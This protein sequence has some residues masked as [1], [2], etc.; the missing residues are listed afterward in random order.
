MSPHSS[1][2]PISATNAEPAV[3]IFICGC[4][5]SGTSLLANMFASHPDVFIP[6]KETNAFF[7][8]ASAPTT[9]QQGMSYANL[10][11]AYQKSG[12]KYLAE[13]TPR[14]IEKIEKIRA[15]A[16]N[17][18]FIVMVRDGRDVAAS[19]I[20][21]TG[22]ASDGRTRWVSANRIAIAE[23]QSKDVYIQRYEDLIEAP[24]ESLRSIC[25]FLLIDFNDEMLTY[26]EKSHRWFGA[27][28]QTPGDGRDG[29]GHRELRNWQINQPIFDDR[30][31]WKRLLPWREKVR[32]KYGAG[33]KILKHFNYE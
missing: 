25:D 32:F 8:E 18:K 20:K 31:K 2:T 22:R 21:R 33:K 15:Q 28:G 17:A 10:K 3:E 11:D 29:T 24:C 7:Q 4:G 12:K 14:H 13:K 16:K 19:F 5:H 6:L 26:H 23:Q 1:K 30:G 9:T 27:T